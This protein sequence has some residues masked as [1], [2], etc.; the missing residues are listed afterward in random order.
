[1]VEKIYGTLGESED[2][3]DRRCDDIYFPWDITISSLT[4]QTEP[5]QREIVESQR[6]IAS[7]PEAS[8]SINIRI[9]LSTD[10]HSRT[11]IDEATPTDR[12][13]L[14]T[15]VTSDISDTINHEEELLDE[16]YSTLV[17]HQ[18][19]LECLGDRLQK[20]E[21]TT[22][23]IKDKWHIGDKVMSDFTDTWFHKSIEEIETCLPESTCF[24]HY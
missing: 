12:G 24:P 15:K 7:R 1:M 3:L 21:N 14:V 11:S 13:K 23:T 5:M 18:F 16:T 19:K 22:T 10:S 9:K 20:I 2:T 4:S 6:C 8:T 17:R